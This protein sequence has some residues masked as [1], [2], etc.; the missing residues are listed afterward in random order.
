MDL[1]TETCQELG[2]RTSLDEKNQ[3]LFCAKDVGLLLNRKNIRPSLQNFSLDDK[4]IKKIQT[5]GG[6]KEL[7]FLTESGLKRFL[8]V[9]RSP[10]IVPHAKV[11]NID[12]H[13]HH[14]K[15][16]ESS[17][18]GKLLKIFNGTEMITQFQCHTYKIDL[19]FPLYRIAVEC[20]EDFHRNT[21]KADKERQSCLESMLSC[22]FIRFYPES[23]NFDIHEIANQIFRRM[24]SIQSET[25]PILI[26]SKFRE[27]SL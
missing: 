17:T 10:A 11:F 25:S 22:H 13:D 2:I 7:I 24:V 15:S 20:D 14:F 12:V 4:M 21:M 27:I 9:S 5:K 16:I 18:I 8:C 3:L 1:K 19:Y 26:T 6:L 23:K